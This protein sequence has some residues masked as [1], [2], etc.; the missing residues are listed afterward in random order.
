[1]AVKAIFSSSKSYLYRRKTP[2]MPFS[3]HFF[4]LFINLY[5]LYNKS[6][7]QNKT[8]ETKYNRDKNSN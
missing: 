5:L 7:M 2:S 1:M 3:I 6:Y 4:I 8:K